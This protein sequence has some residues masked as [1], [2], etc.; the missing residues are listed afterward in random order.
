MPA[1]H[2]FDS[3]ESDGGFV[4]S[5]R[6]RHTTYWRDW[7]SDVFS[8]DLRSARPSFTP[9]A[10]SLPTNAGKRGSCGG[11]KDHN[12]AFL[13]CGLLRIGC[14]TCGCRLLGCAIL[15]D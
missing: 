4:F 11:E 12:S 1:L 2:V 8:S 13:S 7:S 3:V 15:S 14:G 9:V 6:R 10:H 5:S